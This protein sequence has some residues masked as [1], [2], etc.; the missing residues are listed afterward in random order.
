MR[1]CVCLLDQTSLQLSLNFIPV[2]VMH[3][4]AP[5]PFF[6]DGDRNLTV[7]AFWAKGKTYTTDAD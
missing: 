2:P 7:Q 5:I 1:P 6:F 4:H 3:P